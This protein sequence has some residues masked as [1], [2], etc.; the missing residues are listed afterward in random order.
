[1]GKKKYDKKK[2]KRVC[3]EKPL[4]K[5]CKRCPRRCALAALQR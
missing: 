4:R 2:A 1:M 3:C 5:M